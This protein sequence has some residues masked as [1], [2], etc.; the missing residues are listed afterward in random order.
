MRRFVIISE[1]RS[2]STMLGS[3]L[4]SHPQVLMH[5]EIFGSG[6]APLNFYGINETLPW[7]TPLEIYLK[8]TRDAEPVRFLDDRVFAD[9][10]RYAIG[11]K[12][13]FDEFADWPAVVDY[14][15]AQ[16]IHIIFIRR[17]NLFDRYLS[18]VEA[19]AT[20]RF[21]STDNTQ[22]TPMPETWLQECLTPD[23]A[24]RAIDKGLALENMLYTT[25]FM[26]PTLELVYE[27]IVAWGD[28][29]SARIC[30]FLGIVAMPLRTE[31]VKMEGKKR[32][33][34][35]GDLT[36]LRQKMRDQGYAERC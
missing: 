30:N 14:I 27:D 26:N 23:A 10:A 16:R 31:T 7:P 4:A 19:W 35:L 24:A 13:K 5:G 2:G 18:E 11:F 6:P 25:F 33:A 9:T 17:R 1:A 29:V 34:L 32:V 22:T 8:K 21:N 15:V 12:F 28:D 36:A 20:G 3:A